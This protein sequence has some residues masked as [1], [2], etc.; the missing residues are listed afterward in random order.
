MEDNSLSAAD[1]L[2]A[3]S[4]AVRDLIAEL[5]DGPWCY[6]E[7][8]SRW[9]NAHLGLFLAHEEL[10]AL[11]GRLKPDADP[12]PTPGGMLTGPDFDAPDVVTFPPPVAKAIADL[13]EV[14]A[15]EK[16]RSGLRTSTQVER[17]SKA[18]GESS[19]GHSPSSPDGSK[20]RQGF[21][22]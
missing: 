1:H 2:A 14:V 5:E 9:D 12:I 16:R 15:L 4:Q 11:L 22:R 8:T 18:L 7:G 3:I 17:G 6:I 13:R 20:S 10:G 19:S 21:Q